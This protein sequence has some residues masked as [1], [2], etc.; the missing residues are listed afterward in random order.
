MTK[1]ICGLCKAEMF[2][3]S[4]ADFVCPNGHFDTPGKPEPRRQLGD[5]EM[6]HR[7]PVPESFPPRRVFGNAHRDRNEATAWRLPSTTSPYYWSPNPA[8]QDEY[9]SLAEHES[10]LR[11][12]REVQE[13]RIASLREAL[14][15]YRTAD[16][17]IEDIVMARWKTKADTAL[18]E[19]DAQ[20]GFSS[21]QSG[22]AEGKGP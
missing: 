5:N 12:A 1:M 18:A 21:T 8:T 7:E 10:A 20:S 14:E 16:P 13:R 17:V 9:L 6:S 19:D 2:E 4:S 22:N 3:K 15:Y 11:E